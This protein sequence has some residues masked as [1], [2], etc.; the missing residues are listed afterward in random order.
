MRITAKVVQ[1]KILIQHVF[2]IALLFIKHLVIITSSCIANL[3]KSNGLGCP[4]LPGIQSE[5]PVLL[6]WRLPDG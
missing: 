5:I 3:Y 1:H 4:Q 6:R 2:Y